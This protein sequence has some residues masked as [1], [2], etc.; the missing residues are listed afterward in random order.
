MAMLTADRGTIRQKGI[1]FA[2]AAFNPRAVRTRVEGDF[3]VLG[4]NPMA[5][6]RSTK[7]ILCTQAKTTRG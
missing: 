3:L 1:R 2:P 6:T 7:T 5:R 4:Q